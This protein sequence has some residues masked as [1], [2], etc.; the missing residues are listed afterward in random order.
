MHIHMT[1]RLSKE[2]YYFSAELLSTNVPVGH[3]S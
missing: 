2:K 3:M 1:N